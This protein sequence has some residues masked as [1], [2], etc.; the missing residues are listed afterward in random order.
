MNSCKFVFMNFHQFSLDKLE[1]CPCF[2]KIVNIGLVDESF[3]KFHFIGQFNSKMEKRHRISNFEE[4]RNHYHRM[5]ISISCDQICLIFLLLS[6][7]AFCYL[8]ENIPSLLVYLI[9]PRNLYQYD[10]QF[11]PSTIMATSTIVG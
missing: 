7:A 1:L 8:I 11:R 6:S 2:S 5:S 3:G 9:S 10:T 4:L